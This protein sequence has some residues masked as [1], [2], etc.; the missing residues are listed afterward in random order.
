MTYLYI[1]SNSKQRRVYVGIG[2][3]I[4]RI[5]QSHNA[6]AEQLL[7]DPDTELLQTPERF[8]SRLDAERAEAAAI[9]V[10]GLMGAEVISDLR[11]DGRPV[12]NR[13][14][15]LGTK[16]LVPAIFRREGRVSYWDLQSTAIVTLKPSAIDDRGTLHAAKGAATF[17]ARAEKY[18]PLNSAIQR[19]D[20]PE[21]LL[22]VQKSSHIVLGH[23][24]LD[25]ARPMN[26]ME[27]GD[28]VFRLVDA[29]ADDVDGLKGKRFDWAGRG[30]GTRITWSDDLSH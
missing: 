10:A 15:V 22:A 27:N 12:T 5:F 24:D 4:L 26:S 9:Y 21:K 17:A 6:D 2:D 11:H 18:W 8:S 30:V 25:S 7:K 29:E 16:H 13:A 3:D 28:G 20:K 1:Y 14:G 19:G 23:W